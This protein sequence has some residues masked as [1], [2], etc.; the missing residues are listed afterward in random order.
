MATLEI[1]EAR[2][3]DGVS[4]GRGCIVLVRPKS[5]DRVFCFDP[6]VTE[7]DAV[8]PRACGQKDADFLCD[9]EEDRAARA[10]SVAEHL[11]AD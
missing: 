6:G 3:A 5:T 1:V 4:E 10:G 9:R 7:P 2:L 11:V 8:A